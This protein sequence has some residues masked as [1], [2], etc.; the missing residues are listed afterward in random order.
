MYKRLSDVSL[1][2]VET[3]D[4]RKFS[5]MKGEKKWETNKKQGETKQFASE[6]RAENKIRLRRFWG[7]FDSHRC[8]VFVGLDF[9]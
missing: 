8:S 9:H 7:I 1:G 4:F 5:E 3:F 2:A 6:L